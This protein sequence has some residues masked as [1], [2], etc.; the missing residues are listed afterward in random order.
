VA[1]LSAALLTTTALAATLFSTALAATL[2]A[3]TLLA[4]GMFTTTTLIAFTIVCHNPP[5]IDLIHFV[6]LHLFKT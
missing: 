6:L 2:L 5:L 3:T 1:T 4:T